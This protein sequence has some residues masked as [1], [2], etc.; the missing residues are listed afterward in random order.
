MRYP[1][2]MTKLTIAL[3]F[4]GYVSSANFVVGQDAIAEKTVA[5]EAAQSSVKTVQV[6]SRFWPADTPM[7]PAIPTPQQHFGFDIGF[8]HLD[9]AQVVD[10]IQRVV[11]ASDRMTVRTYAKTHGGRPLLE[12]TITSKKNRSQLDKIRKS[13]RA[14]T[15]ADSASVEIDNLP[16]VINMGYGVHGDE[17]SA[18]NCAPLVVYYLAAAETED[19][20]EWL[21]NCVVLL[22]P[23]L[24]PDGFNRFAN[25]ANRYRGLVVNPD[26]QHAEHNQ[27]WPPG[28]VNYYWFDLNRDWLPAVHPESQGRLKNFH[29]WKPNVVLDFHEMGSGS[30]YFFQPGIPER[31]NPLTPVRNQ[32]L[33]RKFAT[34]HSKKLDE[35]GSLYF[36][37]ERFDDFYMGK[38][39]TYPDLHG[40]VG[41]LFEQASSRG[42]VQQTSDGLLTFHDTI[43][44]QFTTSLTSLK[45][46]T[47]MRMELLDYK[48]TFYQQ[49]LKNAEKYPVKTFVFSIPKNPTRLH[50]FATLL[51]RHDIQCFQFKEDFAYGDRMF[52][53]DS[54]IVVPSDQAEHRFLRSLLMRRKTFREN[55]FYDVSSWTLSLAYGLNQFGLKRAVESE[56]LKP[57][58]WKNDQKPA[59][60]NRNSFKFDPSAVSYVIDYRDDM[61]CDVLTRLV[62]ADVKVRVAMK[63]FEIATKTGTSKFP[64][65]SLSVVMANQ[66]QR[67]P[68]IKRILTKYAGDVELTPVKSGLSVSGP[69]IGSPNFSLIKAPKL[70]MVTGPS[71]TSYGAGEIWHMLDHN[72]RMPVTLLKD[73]R[74]SRTDLD[75]YTTLILPD[76]SVTDQNW[77]AVEA[78][79]KS[80]GTVV[81]VGRQAVSVQKRLRKSTEGA[82]G[83]G[84]AAA[85]AKSDEATA[86]DAGSMQ[87]PFNSASNKQALQLISGAIFRTQA[88]LTH[89][90]LFGSTKKAM[91]VFRNHNTFLTPS[92]N[93]YRNPMIY[94]AQT[95]LMAGYCS[96]ENVEKFKTSA[97]VVVEQHG[98]GQ[99]ILMADNPNFRG[100]WHGT[101]RLFLNA[102]LL[103]DKMRVR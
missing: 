95:P 5:I 48:R 28:R 58:D 27:M 21:D 20:K 15:K 26:P 77:A 24:N 3:I 101:S 96:D 86:A 60:Q 64:A 13:H 39:S 92:R 54:C 65:G 63:P 37:Q 76:G 50:R 47:E 71:I 68:A 12:V 16:A 81:A 19:V 94:D 45:A 84:G 61:A 49:S 46:T 70:A 8:R 35:R 93:V 9:H 36:T 91:A 57:I 44:N 97:S 85:I 40:S 75:E 78:F 79:A 100:F 66:K 52:E 74:L 18:T 38:G 17:S 14:L 90:L 83:E 10:Y 29:S 4:F 6:D 41:I 67:L 103:G 25:W 22:D 98:S 7:N 31:T 62:R 1:E 34:F 2:F 59:G 82:S 56:L 88:D 53:A 99:F 69:D 23:S 87:Q 89:P 32:K 42:H 11:K 102:V 80:G 72:L 73:T 33:T 43:A 30:T 51:R 55:I